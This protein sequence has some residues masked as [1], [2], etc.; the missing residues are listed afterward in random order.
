MEFFSYNRGVLLG[1]TQEE[2]SERIRSM[3]SGS[4]TFEDDKELVREAFTNAYKNRTDISVLFR[5]V[6]KDGGLSWTKMSAKCEIENGEPVFY[7][8]LQDMDEMVLIRNRMKSILDCIAGDV[9]R[10]YVGEKT[11]R[12]EVL[13]GNLGKYLGYGDE[14]MCVKI[15]N[16]MGEAFYH[17]EDLEK[18][19]LLCALRYNDHEPVEVSARC[20]CN[21][22]EYCRVKCRAIYSHVNGDGQ[23][24]YDGTLV[25]DNQ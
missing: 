8:I 2:Y 14:E 3:G 16:E 1:Y 12:I 4:L 5:S 20:L 13:S 9:V 17:P 21:N 7:G 19:A 23:A 24:V 10:I 11:F 22:G 18:V 6:R 25:I 15:M